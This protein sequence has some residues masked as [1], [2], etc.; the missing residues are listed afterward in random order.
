MIAL[1]E[2]RPGVPAALGDREVEVATARGIGQGIVAG[3]T[4]AL[5]GELEQG[6]AEAIV[7]GGEKTP[8]NFDEVGNH[9]AFDLGTD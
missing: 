5:V 7:A 6:G 8:S 9:A 2:S 1:G 3:E 4:A